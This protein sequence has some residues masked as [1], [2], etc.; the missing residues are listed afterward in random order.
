MTR[1]MTGDT[2]CIVATCAFG[3]GV[4][5][6]DVR[7]VVHYGTPKSLSN[8]FQESGRAGRD[9][10]QSRCILFTG[11]QELK[12][13][14]LRIRDDC[15]LQELDDAV[16]RPFLHDLQIVREYAWSTTICRHRAF[17]RYFG[18][19]KVEGGA[20]CTGLD[21][22]PNCDVCAQGV[23][24]VR[25][26]SDDSSILL[27]GIAAF[28][29]RKLSTSTVLRIITGAQSIHPPYKTGKVFASGQQHRLPYW[30][31]LWRLLCTNGFAS[32]TTHQ[33]TTPDGHLRT[34]SVGEVT[35]A[36]M[37]ALDGVR[38][39]LLPLPAPSVSQTASRKRPRT[40]GRDTPADDCLQ[41]T[42]P[43][44]WTALRQWRAAT[45]KTENRP[46]YTICTNRTLDQIVATRPSTLAELST[47]GGMGDKRC[48][49]YGAE[50]INI[51]GASIRAVATTT[52]DAESV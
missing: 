41:K 27:R 4:D 50:M 25:D 2:D 5:K 42:H 1:F 6:P 49:R 20:P 34:Y 33:F 12:M 36:G 9:G 32:F 17:E 44:M 16:I 38:R 3:M 14:E 46:A 35:D 51:V 23:V 24:P 45:A 7:L 8:L 11:T 13:H 52:Q 15:R 19:T 39:I 43:P 28:Q 31:M 48:K 47:I 30:T 37:A 18:A 10:K 40:A 29:E 22:Q 21:G 26:L